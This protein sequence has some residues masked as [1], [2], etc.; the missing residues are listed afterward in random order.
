MFTVPLFGNKPIFPIDSRLKM[1][2]VIPHLTCLLGESKVMQQ[3]LNCLGEEAIRSSLCKLPQAVAI[4][5]AGVLG[6][7]GGM[8]C[9]W[10]GL[11]A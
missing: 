7:V 4:R 10:L 2:P 1:A 8:C 5:I 6:D 3:D 11:L 9:W